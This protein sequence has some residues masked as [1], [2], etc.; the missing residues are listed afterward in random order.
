[1]MGETNYDI[2]EIE[3]DIN[4]AFEVCRVLENEIKKSEVGF[5]KIQNNKSDIEN[6]I[7]RMKKNWT[8]RFEEV[9]KT[10]K[11]IEDDKNQEKTYK[12][13][14]NIAN[15]VKIDHE[16]L[17]KELNK[18]KYRLEKYEKLNIDPATISNQFTGEQVR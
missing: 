13:L 14:V 12:G 2:D 9:Q 3:E 7:S 5:W 15:K 17:I 4:I 11:K 16:G 1:M 8:D 10:L 6:E 18:K